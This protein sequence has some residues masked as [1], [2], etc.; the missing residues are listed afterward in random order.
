VIDDAS[1]SLDVD[2]GPTNN[3]PSEAPPEPAPPEPAPPEPAPPES[4]GEAEQHEIKFETE[5]V[6]L[7]GGPEERVTGL[8]AETPSPL[9][10]T[11]EREEP[12]CSAADPPAPSEEPPSPPPFHTDEIEESDL[13]AGRGE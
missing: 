2:D 11:G 5:S 1:E 4:F 6:E 9:S 10:G 7:T 8:A 13:G 12:A 3:A